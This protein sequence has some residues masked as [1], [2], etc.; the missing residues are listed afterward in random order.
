M[1][2]PAAPGIFAVPCLY[3]V[4][5][6]TTRRAAKT[7]GLC[8]EIQNKARNVGL[9]CRVIIALPEVLPVLDCKAEWRF[10]GPRTTSSGKNGM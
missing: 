6:F 5:V 1:C 10:S 8:A 2:R 9:K 4:C 7:V 3:D